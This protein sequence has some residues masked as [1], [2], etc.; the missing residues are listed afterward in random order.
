MQGPLLIESHMLVGIISDT[1]DQ[2]A[3]TCLAV[4]KLVTAGAEVLFHC[5]DLVEPEMFECFTALP[6]YFVFGNND[7]Y[8]AP[9]IRQA[10][11]KA[12][13][14]VCLEW[15]DVVQLAGKRIAITHGHLNSDVQRLLATNPD[16]LLSGHSHI[17]A[18]W[19]SGKTRRI[20]P[21]ALHRAKIFSCA[22]LN[23]ETDELKFIEIPR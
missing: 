1:H 3:R 17:A 5:G 23:L 21:G 7:D 11:A 13:E 20:N 18:T 2:A 9:E 22:I 19:K 12:H 16:Y 10:I 6:T 14:S 8:Y 15:G 4:Q